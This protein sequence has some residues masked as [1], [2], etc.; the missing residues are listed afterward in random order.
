M[1]SRK[2]FKRTDRVS[3]E[4]RREVGLLVHQAVRDALLPEISVSDVEVT[5]DFSHATVYFTALRNEA[6]AP[7]LS[8][9]KELSREMRMQLARRL[10]MR[11]TPE[12]HFRYDSSVEQGE[13]IEQLLRE[14]TARNPAADEADGADAGGPAVDEEGSA[15]AAASDDRGDDVAGASRPGSR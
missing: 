13:R 15:S 3:A 9:L 14:S 2:S 12:L 11:N 8:M 6:A 4:L 5:R 10:R 7:A 1:P